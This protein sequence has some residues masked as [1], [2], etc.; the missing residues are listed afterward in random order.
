[1]S[2]GFSALRM[3]ISGHALNAT[4]CL[5]MSVDASVLYFSVNFV[6]LIVKSS[7]KRLHISTGK[8]KE[9]S[10]STSCRDTNLIFNWLRHRQ[11]P[12]RLSLCVGLR[13]LPD[14]SHLHVRRETVSLPATGSPWILLENANFLAVLSDDCQISSKR[15]LKFYKKATVPPRNVIDADW[16]TDFEWSCLETVYTARNICSHKSR[17]NKNLGLWQ[18]FSYLT[19]ILTN[20]S[21]TWREI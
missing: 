20:F 4:I 6:T 5:N 9:N 21:I 11:Q 2:F 10:W 3:K 8:R 17:S 12:E 13:V 7:G 18:F 15:C 16:F 19:R 1:M 14:D